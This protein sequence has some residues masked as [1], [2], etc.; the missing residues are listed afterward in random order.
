MGKAG[1]S[2]ARDAYAEKIR[3]LA[4]LR[5]PALFRA[6]SRVP[7]EEFLG[8]APWRVLRPA[9]LGRG[10][11]ETSDAAELYDN[12][13]V[14]IDPARRLNNGEPAA[15]L[16]WLDSLELAPGERFLHVGCGVGYY[17]AIAAE[18]LRPGGRAL[19]V[20]LDPD[21]AERARR[22]LAGLDDVEIVSG[23]G[24]ALAGDRFDA[25]FVNAGATEILP[26]WLDSLTP[27]GRL[28]LPLTV[29]IDLT[30]HGVGWMLRVRHGPDGDTAEFQGPVGVFH[31]D[32]A[33]TEYGESR[34]RRFF[35]A[36]PSGA[37]PL[38]R[39]PHRED[40]SCALHGAGFC[41]AH[42]ARH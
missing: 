26:A 3:G 33:R 10:Y 19:G 13:L 36:R 8:P 12:V 35:A 27:G 34:L 2:L 29:G 23:D 16:R 30:N 32:G 14:A 37:F 15:L 39:Q 41:L 18:A 7:R 9:E 6:L 11:Q 4:G 42:P 24:A 20:E 5:S 31:C 1:L 40:S 21:L 17:T 28:L 38:R 25:I 22:N